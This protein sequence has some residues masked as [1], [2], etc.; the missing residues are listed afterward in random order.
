MSQSK[1]L[2]KFYKKYLKWILSGAKDHKYFT[3]TGGLYANASLYSLHKGKREIVSE[4]SEQF[5]NQGLDSLYPFG[6]K[7]FRKCLDN[8]SFHKQKRRVNWVKD[9][10]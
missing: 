2:T 5:S 10:V 3:R 7:K 6:R 4:M 9:H 1:R 8:S